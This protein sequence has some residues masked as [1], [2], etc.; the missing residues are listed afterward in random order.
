MA[1]CALLI[2]IAL[3]LLSP[4]IYLLY[5]K[6][7]SP[8]SPTTSK[9]TLKG[10][11][12]Y[13]I[14]RV[15]PENISGKVRLIDGGKLWSATS[16]KVIEAGTKVKVND[17]EGVHLIVEVIEKDK[18]EEEKK[19]NI[20][21]RSFRS[22]QDSL[23]SISDFIR[24][25]S[26]KDQIGPIHESVLEEGLPEELKESEEKAEIG[27]GE[28]GESKEANGFINSIQNKIVSTVS[29]LKRKLGIST[30]TQAEEVSTEEGEDV[31]EEIPSEEDEDV[32]EE[33]EELSI[34]P[35]CEN[36]IPNDTKKCPECG[37]RIEKDEEEDLEDEIFEV[38][39]DELEEE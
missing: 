31:T 16:E 17:V 27:G 24:K 22:V 5:L 36:I 12:G 2:I 21:N 6:F 32:T 33:R 13:V 4:F 26:R 11:E 7:F 18:K 35:D 8:P 14:K 39:D 23:S 10:R 20:L 38:I 3:L 37:T 9:V 1:V 25:K 15:R 29:F 30:K 19:S 28:E 34:C